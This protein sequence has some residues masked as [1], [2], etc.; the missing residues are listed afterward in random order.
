MRNHRSIDLLAPT[1]KTPV[2]WPNESR[3]SSRYWQS[4][5]DEELRR[6]GRYLRQQAQAGNTVHQQDLDQARA[7]WR[8]RHPRT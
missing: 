4:M 8:R 3:R 2:E 5:S 1:R 7:E 6:V